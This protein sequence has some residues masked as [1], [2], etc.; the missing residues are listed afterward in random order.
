MA[1][2]APRVALS[3]TGSNVGNGGKAHAG[4]SGVI[5]PG[6]EQLID[7]IERIA[8]A[9]EAEERVPEPVS[10]R[11]RD[12]REFVAALVAAD[13]LPAGWNRPAPASTEDLTAV[14]H[15]ALERVSIGDSFEGFVEWLMPFDEPELAGA[16]FAVRARYRVGN[17]HGQGGMRV[18]Q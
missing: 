3:L 1:E 8:R 5:T 12:A 10:E 7:L 4:G 17:L 18:F 14:L 16:D 6:E 13:D 2:E 11:V 9:V 15:D